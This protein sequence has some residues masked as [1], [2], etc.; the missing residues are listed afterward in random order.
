MPSSMCIMCPLSPSQELMCPLDQFEIVLFSLTGPDGKTYPLCP[1]CYNYPPFEN[2]VG[3]G[4]GGAGDA[5][6]GA[7]AQVGLSTV[8]KVHCKHV[9]CM[10]P[11]ACTF[12]I[13][14]SLT[15]SC[16]LAYELLHL[17]CFICT[18]SSV[19]RLLYMG[20]PCARA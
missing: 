6:A 17:Y 19:S 7:G 3:G 13:A 10:F 11:C 16:C 12:R 9:M 15:L 14:K 20:Q 5:K 4:G 8:C 1:Y 18:A 2:A